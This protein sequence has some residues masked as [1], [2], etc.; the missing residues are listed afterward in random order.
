[1]DE[2]N[3]SGNGTIVYLSFEGGFYGIVSDDGNRYDALNLDPEFQV[4]GLRIRFVAE[5]L[6]VATFHMWGTPV[7]ILK[8]EKLDE[9]NTEIPPDAQNLSGN[10][11][12]LTTPYN[13]AIDGDWNTK[14][15]WDTGQL[16]DFSVSIKQNYSV[17]ATNTNVFME[18]KA[19]QYRHGSLM[20]TPM[21]I[22][23]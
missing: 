3:V 6:H 1:T 9:T 21:S 11:S 5:I 19:Y 17:P 8:L 16:G 12:K 23:F 7:S 10:L 14:I 15:A 13:N 22:Q 20:P 4:N 2:G 18:F